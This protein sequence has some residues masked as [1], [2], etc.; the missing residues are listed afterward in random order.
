[1][2]ARATY[3]FQDKP[4]RER[5]CPELKR[6][7]SRSLKTGTIPLL[8]TVSPLAGFSAPGSRY[9]LSN[10]PSS[11]GRRM[12]KKWHARKLPAIIFFLEAGTQTFPIL[13]PRH[14]WNH[15][16]EWPEKILQ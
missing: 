5:D 13:Q 6:P 8:T 4:F 11:K 9:A 1:M 7:D 15:A 2:C 10:S 16:P 14:T 3:S 12:L